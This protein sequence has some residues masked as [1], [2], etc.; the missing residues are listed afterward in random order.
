LVA[1]L[2]L[3]PGTV[4]AQG[5]PAAAT[6]APAVTSGSIDLIGRGTWFSDGSDAARFQRYRDVRDGGTLDGLRVFG[7]NESRRYRL[8]A[9]HVGY[10]DQRYTASYTRFGSLKASF[11]WNQSPLFFSDTTATLFSAEGAGV[12]RVSDSIQRGLEEGTTTAAAAVGQAVPFERRTARGVLNLEVTYHPRQDLQ[13]DAEVR[14]TSGRI[15]SRFFAVSTRVSPFV[16]EEAAE[17]Q[18]SASAESTFAA[19]SKELRVRVEASKKRFTTLLPR[20]DGTFLIGRWR[21][22]F[23]ETARSSTSRSSSRA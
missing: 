23:M 10:R 21:T 19:I 5:T 4:L 3:L 11:E 22:S 16:T 15:A 18:L 12:L 1:A 9:D 17:V 8:Q 2:L 6:P 14:S 20:S 7:E 13:F